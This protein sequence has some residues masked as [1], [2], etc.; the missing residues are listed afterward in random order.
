MCRQPAFHDHSAGRAC[1]GGDSVGGCGLNA[2][3]QPCVDAIVGRPGNLQRFS[4][5]CRQPAS[6]DHGEAAR[7]SGVIRLG[8][9]A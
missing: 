8:A 5:V 9:A 6:H 2:N 3:P 4:T 1:F 7:A